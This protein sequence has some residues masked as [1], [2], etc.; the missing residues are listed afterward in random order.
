[1]SY[2]DHVKCTSCRAQ[3]DPESLVTIQG[4]ARCP[5]CGGEIALKDLFGLRDAF[6]EEEA[7]QVTIDDLVPGGPA[8]SGPSRSTRAPSSDGRQ[9]P[10]TTGSA[11]DALRSI[12]KGKP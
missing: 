9:L 3:L 10:A 4:S 11:L 2:F 1:M 5:K 7:P 6:A 12:K 8:R